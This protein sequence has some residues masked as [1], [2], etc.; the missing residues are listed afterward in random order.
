[1]TD[2]MYR[3]QVADV[4]SGKGTRG[5]QVKKVEKELFEL[6]K[7]PNLNIKPK[8]LEQ[9]GGQYYSDAACE[10][11]NSIYNDKG[12]VIVVCY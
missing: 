3:A 5:E 8:Q 9:R 6:Y 1:M 4:K 7:D 10:L 11:I 2:E 12:T